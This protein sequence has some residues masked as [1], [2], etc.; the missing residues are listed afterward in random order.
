MTMAHVLLADFQDTTVI[1]DRGY[2]ADSLV[3][4]LRA[5]RCRVVIPSRR[6]R[7]KKRRTKRELYR[8]RYKVECFFQRLKRFRRIGTRYEKRATNYL[9]MILLAAAMIWMVAV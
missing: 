2:D 6:N 8:T 4:E 3:D 5:Q 7:K 9:G 1:A